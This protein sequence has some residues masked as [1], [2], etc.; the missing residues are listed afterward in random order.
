MKVAVFIAAFVI[1]SATALA[2]STGMK[3]ADTGKPAASTEKTQSTH[4]AN[5]V[6][7]SVDRM[8]ATVLLAHEAV[9]TLN[10]PAMTMAFKV[11]DRTVLDRI[12]PGSKVEIEFQKRGSDY[13]IT[14]MR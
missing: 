6:V 11:Q 12:A 14:R 1:V 9:K 3:G 10:W 2:Q 7:K 5:G 13:V 8:E 4:R